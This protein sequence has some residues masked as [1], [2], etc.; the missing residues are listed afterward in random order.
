MK[1]SDTA[2][3]H[4]ATAPSMADALAHWQSAGL[5]ALNWFGSGTLDRMSGMGA[6]WMAFVAER[7]REDVALQHALLHAKTPAEVQALQMTFLQK[8]LD[9]YTAETGKMMELGS[10][11]FDATAQDATDED[12]DDLANNVNV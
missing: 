1:R 8:A 5:G 3:D 2:K 11:L 6:E 10:R 7:V 9:Q 12:T 4:T